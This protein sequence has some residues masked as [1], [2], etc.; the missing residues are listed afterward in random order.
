MRIEGA[1]YT[2]PNAILKLCV[3][4]LYYIGRASISLHA[5]VGLSK[6]VGDIHHLQ[7]AKGATTANLPVHQV[8]RA[9]HGKE[10]L[11]CCVGLLC[12]AIN[13]QVYS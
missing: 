1:M 6:A 2:I 7:I 10:V 4:I 3:I 13:L 8:V 9:N 11:T 12:S 5:A